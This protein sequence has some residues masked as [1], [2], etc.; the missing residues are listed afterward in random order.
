MSITRTFTRTHVHVSFSD[1]YLTCGQ[2]GAWVKAWH[3]PQQCGCDDSGWE[4]LPCGHQA[5]ATGVC[6]SWGPV[7][8]CTCLETF[9]SVPHGQPSTD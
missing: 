9:G 8:G 3:D 5:E 7:D 1:P 4:L 6:P 2:C